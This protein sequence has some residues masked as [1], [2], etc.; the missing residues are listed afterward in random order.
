[1]TVPG[2]GSSGLTHWQSLWEKENPKR[3]KR[4]EQSNWDLPV[5]DTWVQHIAKE[6]QKLDAHPL[7]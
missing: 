6:V 3:F 5:R 4:I 2:L 7:I 1:M